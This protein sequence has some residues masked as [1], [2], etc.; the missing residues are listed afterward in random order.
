MEKRRKNDQNLFAKKCLQEALLY[1]LKNHDFNKITIT[2]LTEKAGVSRMTFYR[3]YQRIT[4]LVLDY[5][6]ETH[7]GVQDKGKNSF[8]LPNMIRGTFTFFMENQILIKQLIDSGNSDVIQKSIE[9]QFSRNFYLLLSSYGFESE[10]EISALVGIFCK[11]L[12]DWFR[13]GMQEGI[14][15]MVIIVY[16]IM[17]KFDVL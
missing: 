9:N 17:T 3:N 15:Q 10:Y 5:F 14:E 13:N 7:F 12:I 1:L 2:K 4:D 8:Y 11:I 16:K 6:E